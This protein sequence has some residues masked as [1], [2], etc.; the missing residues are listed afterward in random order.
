MASTGPGPSSLNQQR[1][2][3]YCTTSSVQAASRSARKGDH[4]SGRVHTPEASDAARVLQLRYL[5]RLA[6]WCLPGVN[7]LGRSSLSAP[8]VD[9][10]CCRACLDRRG[11]AHDTRPQILCFVWRCNFHCTHTFKPAAANLSQAFACLGV[12]IDSFCCRK[13]KCSDVLWPS[14]GPKSGRT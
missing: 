11:E 3:K 8:A 4:T 5:S 10:A 13:M 1:Q 14:T 2:L 6:G 9:H 12:D 7:G